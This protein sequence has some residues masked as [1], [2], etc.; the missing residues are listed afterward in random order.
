MTDIVEQAR[1][2]AETLEALS[3]VDVPPQDKA[4]MSWQVESVL[5]MRQAVRDNVTMAN[6]IEH[7][8]LS[9][10]EARATGRR[11]GLSEAAKIADALR[12]EQRKFQAHASA[13][14]FKSEA[15]DHESMKFAAVHFAAA[16]RAAMEKAE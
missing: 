12:D 8:R 2:R 14:G 9:L 16:I 11:E 13:N 4:S 5:A 7:L 3:L 15:R 10:S 6:E 1:R